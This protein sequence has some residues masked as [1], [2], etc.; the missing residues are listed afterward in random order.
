MPKEQ[1]QR[2]RV[3]QRRRRQYVPYVK[4]F[5]PSNRNQQIRALG[6]TDASAI[7]KELSLEGFN[8]IKQCTSIDDWLAQYQEEGQS[9]DDYMQQC[10]WLSRRKCK[11]MPQR[12]VA[13]GT[14]LPE[15]YPDGKIYIVPLGDFSGGAQEQLD[16]LIE[17][18]QI[19]LGLP[20]KQMTN[21]QLEVKANGIYF[22]HSQ[23]DSKPRLEKLTG[24]SKEHKGDMKHQLCIV[25]GLRI[26]K[27]YLPQDALCMIALTRYDLYEAKRDLFVAGMAAGNQ[28][29]AIF[30]LHRYNPNLKFSQEFWYD[31]SER[32]RVSASQTK[33]LELQ[34]GCRLLVHEISHLLGIGHCIYFDCCMNGSGHLQ[35]DFNQPMHFCPIDLRKLQTLVGFDIHE[36]YR[37]LLQFYTKHSLTSDKQW[38]EQRLELISR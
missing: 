1:S 25:D 2:T 22:R 23:T 38:V 18:T 10:P 24:R 16:A 19:F 34:R 6:Y 35:E 36:R 37:R 21:M 3:K 4:G 15:K 27:Q 13:H 9:Y 32:K 29:V 31:V 33:K 17:Y 7:P 12:F 26:L 11:Y 14:N 5:K 8:A 30:S 28:R 20:V